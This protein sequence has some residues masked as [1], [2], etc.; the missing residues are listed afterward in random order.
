MIEFLKWMIEFL[1]KSDSGGDKIDRVI[2][3]RLIRITLPISPQFWK[4]PS[5]SSI[6]S[7]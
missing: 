7:T 5:S 3:I 6:A 2:S 4:G 1:R